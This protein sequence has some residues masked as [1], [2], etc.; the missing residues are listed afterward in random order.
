MLTDGDKGVI[1][2]RDKETYAVA[3][4][5]P[6]GIISSDMLRKIADVADRYHAKEL[7]ITSAA[8]I[9]IIGL[10][11]DDID[12]VW[13][14]L[15]MQPGAT[16]GLCIRSI[17]ACPGTTYCKRGQQDSLSMGKYLDKKYHGMPLPGKLKIGVAGCGNKCAETAI[18][19]IGLVGTQK[20]WDLFVGGCGGGLP[21]LAERLTRN[22]SDAEAKE[23]IDLIIHYFQDNARRHERMGKFID[24]VGIEKFKESI[25]LE[26]YS[27]D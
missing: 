6:C 19:D 23:I 24:R 14:D 16:V 4:H 22:L 12:N 9:A 8:R 1:I 26:Q 27:T 13:K 18:K 17:K 25:N 2:Q 15:Q 21:R 11:E 3:P 7:K 10:N 20:G 5:I